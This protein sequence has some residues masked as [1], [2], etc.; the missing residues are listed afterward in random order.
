MKTVDDLKVGD[1]V[2]W[3]DVNRK[4]IHSGTVLK[5]GRKL[6]TVKEYGQIVFRKDNLRTNDDYGHQSLIVDLE[7]YQERQ[8]VR[9]VLDAIYRAYGG[10]K[11]TPLADALE[12]ARLLR[13]EAPE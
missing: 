3:S 11:D 12:A 4:G 10:S 8:K 13:V 2:W 9:G 1:K 5:V 6:V 7:A